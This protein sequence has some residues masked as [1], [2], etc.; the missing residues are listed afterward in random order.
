MALCVLILRDAPT[1]E[2]KEAID[3]TVHACP[4]IPALA[5]IKHATPAQTVA[6]ALV[7]MVHSNAQAGPDG[8]LAAN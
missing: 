8:E 1:P 2:A 4:E 7:G 3:F 6:R 5:E